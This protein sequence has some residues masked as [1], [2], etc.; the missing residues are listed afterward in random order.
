MATHT[1][2]Y[3]QLLAQIAALATGPKVAVPEKY[4]GKKQGDKAYKFIAACEQYIVL[5]AQQFAS[6][7]DL[8][9]WALGYMTEEAQKWALIIIKDITSATPTIDTWGKFRQ[10][11]EH[12][13][14]DPDRTAKAETA[15]RNLCQTGSA[16]TYTAEFSKQAHHVTWNDQCHDYVAPKSNLNTGTSSIIT[17]DYPTERTTEGYRTIL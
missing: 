2:T 17:I 15:L 16:A 5:S 1:P 9:N 8:I 11:F 13:F 12:A 6:D 14:G 10:T 3:D 7:N 4:D